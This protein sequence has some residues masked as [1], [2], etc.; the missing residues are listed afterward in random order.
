MFIKIKIILLMLFVMLADLLSKYFIKLFL[1]EDKSKFYKITDFLNIVYVENHGIVF[2]TM[3]RT[4]KFLLIAIVLLIML[5]LASLFKKEK[6]HKKKI[7][8]ALIAG[9]GFGNLLDR[10]INGYVFDFIDFHVKNYHW[11]AFNVADAFITISVILL[12][13]IEF[14]N[15]YFRNRSSIK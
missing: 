3:Q 2:G 12:I 5:S 6:N 15:D 11:Y 14:K 10:I 8:L 4:N 13:I 7:M 1:F 9:G